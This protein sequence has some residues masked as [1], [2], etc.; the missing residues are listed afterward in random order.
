MPILVFQLIKFFGVFQTRHPQATTALLY[1]VSYH[2]FKARFV[3]TRTINVG[4]YVTQPGIFRWVTI[5]PTNSRGIGVVI[6]LT[7]VLTTFV[8]L[9]LASTV[10]FG[11]H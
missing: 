6:E 11:Q 3:Q 5:G 8:G 9:L 1:S 7:L 2:H 4:A 10:V